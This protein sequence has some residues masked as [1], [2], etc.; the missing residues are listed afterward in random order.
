M[1]SK[2]EVKLSATQENVL[3]L[4]GSGHVDRAMV[5]TAYLHAHYSREENEANRKRYKRENV[6]DPKSRTGL[7]LM[8]RVPY[9][10]QALRSLKKLGLVTESP[11]GTRWIQD[12]KLT[13]LGREVLAGLKETR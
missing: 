8:E 2:A 3:Q 10:P 1:T 6:S 13:K 12:V 4:I 11:S 7:M 5:G 9:G